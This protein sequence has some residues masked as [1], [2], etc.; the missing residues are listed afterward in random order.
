MSLTS[1]LKG[2]KE[3]DIEL[4]TI[5]REIIPSKKDFCTVSGNEAFSSKYSIEAP[6]NLNYPQQSSVV[7]TAFDYMARFIVAQKINSNKIDVFVDLTAGRGLEIIKR[8][9]NKKTIRLLEKKFEDGINLVNEFVNNNIKFEKL[10]L[11]AVYMARLEIVY[12][13]GIPPKDI[14]SS[15]LGKEESEIVV[16]LKQLCEVFIER[17]IIPQVITSNSNVV[18]N[19]HFG[20]A[21]LSC[22]GADADIYIDGTLYDFKTTKATGYRW[23]E[24]AQIF[25]YYLLNCI[26][27][28][29][30]DKSAKLDNYEIKRLA[31]Y[32]ARYGEIEYIDI[33]IM[34]TTEMELAVKKINELLKISEFSIARDELPV[35]LEHYSK[36][37][38]K[39][40]IN[41][42][43]KVIIMFCVLFVYFLLVYYE[44]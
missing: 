38:K 41:T 3:I 35:K 33:S 19:P 25:S 13:S 8:Y 10:L 18:F 5:L 6:Y 26:A 28:D 29:L 44:K 9:C 24:I 40:R 31:F 21:S 1:M 42:F 20:V 22:G 37:N 34:E 39:T 2:K 30:K 17:F 16:D 4:Q 27:I 43:S 14:K 7:G 32:K 15:M 12:R 11:F 36:S 23:Q